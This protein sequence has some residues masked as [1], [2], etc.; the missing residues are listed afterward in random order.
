MNEKWRIDGV[1][2]KFIHRSGA[3]GYYRVVLDKT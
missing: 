2:V 3:G 1:P